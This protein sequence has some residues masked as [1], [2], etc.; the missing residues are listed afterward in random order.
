MQL[1]NSGSLVREL[2]AII[3]AEHTTDRG[4]LSVARFSYVFSCEL[5]GP[6]WAEGSYSISQSAGGISQKIIFKTLRQIGCPALYLLDN[7]TCFRIPSSVQNWIHSGASPH[8]WYFVECVLENYPGWW[9]HTVATYCPSRPSQLS[10]KIIT[11]HHEWGD[12]QDYS[13]HRKL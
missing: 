3:F 8:S 1:R 6:A 2:I 11:K 7:V 5:R 10:K 9:A 4:V 12:A 13:Y